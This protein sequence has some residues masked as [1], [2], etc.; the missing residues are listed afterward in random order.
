MIIILTL[1]FSVLMALFF[2]SIRL[3]DSKKE[4]FWQFFLLYSVA[5]LFLVYALYTYERGVFEIINGYMRIGFI[6]EQIYIAAFYIPPTF[7]IAYLL[8]PFKILKRNR[9][10]IWVLLGYTLVVVGG[11]A[12]LNILVTFS[13]M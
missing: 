7:L 2:G 5:L 12:L 11:S 9:I 1:V 3:L 8:Y 10:L 13:N 4:E 6:K